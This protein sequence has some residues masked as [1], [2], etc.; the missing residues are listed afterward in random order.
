MVLGL[1]TAFRS[2]PER[3]KSSQNSVPLY[4]KA[5]CVQHRPQSSTWASCPQLRYQHF[6]HLLSLHGSNKLHAGR[7]ERPGK[8]EAWVR[9]SCLEGRPKTGST[10]VVCLSR[11][12]S[13][14]T[15]VTVHEI[16]P[17]I[18]LLDTDVPKTSWTETRQLSPCT[19]VSGNCFSFCFCLLFVIVTE[20]TE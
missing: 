15:G 19:P 3:L 7:T 5:L 9:T 4:L 12:S 11:S 10:K 16:Q 8:E 13:S 2:S 20:L 6:Q 17:L 14:R 18:T 1:M